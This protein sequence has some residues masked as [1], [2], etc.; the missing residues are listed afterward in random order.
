MTRSSMRLCTIQHIISV[1]IEHIK[2]D[3][4]GVGDLKKESQQQ[5]MSRI[6]EVVEGLQL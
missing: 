4:L 2:W 1:V 5:L 6:V 3:W